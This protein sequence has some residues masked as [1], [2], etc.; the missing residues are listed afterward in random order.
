MTFVK[1]IKD[2]IIRDKNNLFKSF[3]PSSKYSFNFQS[4]KKF[5]NFQTVVVIGMEV[6]FLGQ[7]LFI[8]F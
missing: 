1:K 7:K 8:L 3:L 6:L 5:N 4:I 2:E